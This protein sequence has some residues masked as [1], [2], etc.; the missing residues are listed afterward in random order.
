MIVFWYFAGAGIFIFLTCAGLALLAW[1]EG[2][3]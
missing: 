2:A 1:T 3:G